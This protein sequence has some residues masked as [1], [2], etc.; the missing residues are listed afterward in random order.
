MEQVEQE[1][2]QATITL[3]YFIPEI[4]KPVAH[5][6][7]EITCIFFSAC[8]KNRMQPYSCTPTKENCMD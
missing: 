1:R 7:T 5:C 2:N 3:S 8:S 4:D 6:N